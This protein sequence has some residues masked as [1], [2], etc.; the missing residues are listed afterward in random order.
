MIMQRGSQKRYSQVQIQ[1]ANRGKLIILL[2][3]GAIRNMKKALML[4]E[5]GDMEGKGNKNLL[6]SNF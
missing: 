2:Y 1:T 4:M 5:K 6:F 3:Q